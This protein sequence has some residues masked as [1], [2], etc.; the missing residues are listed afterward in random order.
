MNPFKSFIIPSEFEATPIS[1]LDLEST[2]AT[3]ETSLNG[4]Q[5]IPVSKIFYENK[6]TSYAL[7]TNEVIEKDGFILNKN[8]Q[9]LDFSNIGFFNSILI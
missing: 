5:T 8:I 1:V 9:T 4:T 2:T 3:V 6:P 7:V